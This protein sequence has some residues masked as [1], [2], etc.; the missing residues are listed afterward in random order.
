MQGGRGTAKGRENEH[1]KNSISSRSVIARFG[2][3]ILAGAMLAISGPALAGIE[4]ALNQLADSFDDG[5]AK[6]SRRAR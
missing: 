4:D 2:A 6:A 5:H 3:V 1:Q